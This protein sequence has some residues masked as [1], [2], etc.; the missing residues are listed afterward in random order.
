MNLFYI[1]KTQKSFQIFTRLLDKTCFSPC[2]NYKI[3]KEKFDIFFFSLKFDDAIVW[4]N[5]NIKISLFLLDQNMLPQ[6]WRGVVEIMNI[7]LS[8]CLP[9]MTH[10]VR[11]SPYEHLKIVCWSMGYYYWPEAPPSHWRGQL[12]QCWELGKDAAREVSLPHCKVWVCF[13][14]VWVACLCIIPI[15]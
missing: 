15:S 6:N 4:K 2:E 13:I 5:S 7:Y 9:Q 1:I 12:E 10:S 3:C 11:N 8:S 14:I